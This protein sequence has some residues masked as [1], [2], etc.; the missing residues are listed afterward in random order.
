K[1]LGIRDTGD[2]SVT[3]ED[4]QASLKVRSA[5]GVIGQSEHAILRNVLRLYARTVSSSMVPRTDIVFLDSPLALEQNL[6]RIMESP[7]SRFPVCHRHMDELLGVVN[8]KQLFAQAISGQ[9]IDI[10]ALAQ[11]CHFIPESFSGMA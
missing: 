10:K 4:I 5:S 1:D 2:A 9:D 11:P 7:H 6:Q 8:A 3:E